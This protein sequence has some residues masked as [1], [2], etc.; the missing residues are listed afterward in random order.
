MKA[1]RRVVGLLFVGAVAGGCAKTR[2]LYYDAWEKFGYAKRERLVDNVKAA[3]QEQVEAKQQFAS[4]LDQFKSVVN[5]QGG[6]LEA[7]YNKLNQEYERCED[8]SGQVKSKIQS[9]KN[10]AEALFTEWEG[11]VKEIKGDPDL[12]RQSRQLLD[13]TKANYREMI[14]RMDTA[15]ASMDPVLQ[16]FKNRVLFIKSNLN[17]QAIASLKGEEVKLGA[18]IDKLIR[19]MEAS[20]AE[21]DSFISG[22]QGKTKS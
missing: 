3:R 21:A 16:K 4:A 10:V 11:E 8:Q 2:S 22:I 17:A 7:V 12:Q 9:V 1:L 13:Q 19:D 15:A 6:N 20:I 14:D 5:Y 18:D